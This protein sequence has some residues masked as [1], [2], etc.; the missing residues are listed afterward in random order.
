MQY[1]LCLKNDNFSVI[2]ESD[3]LFRIEI[4][5]SEI[6][7]SEFLR[8]SGKWSEKWSGKWSENER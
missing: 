1:V 4:K 5:I 8:P 6:K 2:H 7:I 3:P